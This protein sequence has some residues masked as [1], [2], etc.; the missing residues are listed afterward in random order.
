VK[1]WVFQEIFDKHQGEISSEKSALP[2]KKKKQTK[3][4]LGC[5]KTLA[6][7]ANNQETK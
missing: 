5:K 6:Q 3:Q 1:L 7:R 4:E 2:K